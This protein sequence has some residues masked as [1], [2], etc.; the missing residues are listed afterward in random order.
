MVAAGFALRLSDS[1]N[2]YLVCR[3]RGD[4]IVL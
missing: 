1:S 4:A 3:C 2:E